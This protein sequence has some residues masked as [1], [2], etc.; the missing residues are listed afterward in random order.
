MPGQEV[1][2]GRLIEPDVRVRAQNLKA[3]VRMSLSTPEHASSPLHFADMQ[4]KSGSRM[5]ITQPGRTQAH[6]GK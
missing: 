2:F 3:E 4:V 1:S 6:L 5:W